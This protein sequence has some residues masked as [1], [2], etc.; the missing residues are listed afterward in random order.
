MHIKPLEH[1]RKVIKFLSNEKNRGLIIF[2]SVGSG[3]TIT[4]LLTAHALHLKYPTRSILITAPVSILA[5]YTK[6]MEKLD[7]TFGDKLV[8]LSYIKFINT[9]KGNKLC[10]GSILIV[11]EA[12]NFN[13]KSGKRASSLI[14][15]ASNAFK[16]LLL[17][18]T[19]VKN[20][21]KELANLYTMITPRHN[22]NTALT[23]RVIE[24]AAQNPSA[25]NHYFKCKVSFFKNTSSKDYPDSK[26][27]IIPLT[28]SNE[29]Y[30][31]YYRIQQNIR[32]DLPDIFKNTKDLEYFANGIRRAVNKVKTVSPKVTWT[33][34]KILSDTAKN[35][36]VLVYSAWKATGINLIKE[37]L[38]KLKVKYSEIHGGLSKSERSEQVKLYNENINKVMI[39]TAA[40]G[41]GI[42]LKET[43]SVIIMEPHWNYARNEQ[44][45][46]RAIRYKSH[47]ALTKSKRHV[48]IYNLILKKPWKKYVNFDTKVGTADEILFLFSKNKQEIIEA[49]YK[50]LKKISIEADVKC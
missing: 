3:K 14:K 43:R 37:V 39:I 21:P 12:H 16:I 35:K 29:F 22:H 5:N 50:R 38:D 44:V 30:D 24:E 25:F 20:N 41:E 8:L 18:A 47:E 48:D 31:Q 49:F 7:I 6:E 32:I 26:E 40:G 46:G 23:E 33:I 13:K 1:Q 10:N 11:D 19:P 28:M 27:H 4:S 45:I 34:D 42:D 2:H 15:C 17:T 9:I 36:K